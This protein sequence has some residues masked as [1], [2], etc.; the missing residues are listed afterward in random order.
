M[1]RDLT[2]ETLSKLM[3]EQHQ[4]DL[5]IDISRKI[6]DTMDFHKTPEIIALGRETYHKAIAEADFA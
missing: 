1:S 3:L 2:Q 4:P 5:R 6:C